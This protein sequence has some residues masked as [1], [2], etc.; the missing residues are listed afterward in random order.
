MAGS[1]IP[2][3]V[4]QPGIEDSL[5]TI[6]GV[7][8]QVVRLSSTRTGPKIVVSPI[9]TP[10][11]EHTSAVSSDSAAPWSWTAA[12]AVDT[13]IALL[14]LLMHLA[15]SKDD[16]D[17]LNYCLSSDDATAAATTPDLSKPE[18]VTRRNAAVIGGM[19]NCIDPASGRSPLHVAALSGSTG[20]VNTLL[21]AGALVHLRDSLGH[22]A[23]YYVRLI[24]QHLASGS[25][26]DF[27]DIGCTSGTRVYRRYARHG[28]CELGR[29]GRRRRVCCYH[30]PK[31]RAFARRARVAHLEKSRCRDAINQETRRINQWDSLVQMLL[32]VDREWQ[33]YTWFQKTL[34]RT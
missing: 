26:T 9:S 34:E 32:Y 22:T 21:E 6:Q 5:D 10:T 29:L 15:A 33:R 4:N 18:P 13:E 2:K 20:C 23:L 27:F 24:R 30:R 7:L 19:A 17:A 31:S 28:W 8:S 3:P 16:V 14:P 12:E 1:N 25:L 11:V